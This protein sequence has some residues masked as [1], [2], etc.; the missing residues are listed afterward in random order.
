MGKNHV[1]EL[2]LHLLTEWETGDRFINLVLED[3]RV[4]ALSSKDRRFLTAL[5]Y[6][7][8]ERL[9]TLDY[10]I[11]QLA[12]RPLKNMAPHTRR[13]LR[14]GLYQLCFMDGVPDHAAVSETVALAGSR[15][16]RGFVNAIMRT[17]QRAPERLALPAGD[18]ARRL[19]LTYS[20]PRSTVRHFLREYGEEM[21]EKILAAFNETQPLTLRVNTPRISRAALLTALREAGYAA[22]ETVYSPVGIRLGESVDPTSLPGFAEGHFFV[23]DEASQIA[24][25]ALGAC[26]GA[27]VV[28]TCAC[29]GGK[30]FGAAMDMGD[31]GTLYAFDLH[32][33]KLP[34]IEKGAARLG[35]SCVRPSVHDGENAKNELCNKAD[36]VICDAPCSGLG[37]LGKKADLRYRGGERLESLPPLQQRIL[38]A[39]A[40]YVRPGG[41]LVYSTCT[42][43][44]AENEDVRAA[45]LASHPNFEAVPFSV[46]A[47]EAPTGSC[48]LLPPVHQTDGFFIA[49]FKRK[50]D[51]AI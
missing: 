31:R 43:N 12:N 49:K 7:T 46:G 24:V 22:E 6:G 14:L 34:L 47:L 25:A 13:V 15:A 3:E 35:L 4:A 32:E 40:Q 41:A 36:Y 45:F 39:A 37:V 11:E 16:E 48:R 2:A 27:L 9:L 30:S 1:R 44:R 50:Q 18:V 20:F 26:P 21:S 23:Q 17:A 28:D 29:P 8:V 5:L 38:D 51:D 42:L 10:Y 19:S 33:S